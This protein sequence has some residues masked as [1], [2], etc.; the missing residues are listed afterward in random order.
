[1]GERKREERE[2]EKKRE[3]ERAQKNNFSYIFFF[4]HIWSLSFS[5]QPK[6]NPCSDHNCACPHKVLQEFQLVLVLKEL[7]LRHPDQDQDV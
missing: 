7:Q 2:R 4:R 6:S 3:R 1:M 5:T